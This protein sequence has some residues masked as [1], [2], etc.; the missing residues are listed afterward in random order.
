M[1]IL[2]DRLV[3]RKHVCHAFKGVGLSDV[4][5]ATCDHWI[6]IVTHSKLASSLEMESNSALNVFLSLISLGLGFHWHCCIGQG[7]QFR[8][9]LLKCRL[10]RGQLR[11]N[12]SSVGCK[13]RRFSIRP[14]IHTNTKL[15]CSWGRGQ[16]GQIHWFVFGRFGDTVCLGCFDCRQNRL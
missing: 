8:P 14:S 3:L 4:D 9:E 11:E 16:E 13:R 2:L 12:E 5:S 7:C 10:Q 1:H 6:S 15:T